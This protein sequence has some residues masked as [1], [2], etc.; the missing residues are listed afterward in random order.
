VL[1]RPHW[2]VAEV[3]EYLNWAEEDVREAFDQL[4]GWALLQQSV[5]NPGRWR[6]TSPEVSLRLLMQRQQAELQE[7]LE[8]QDAITKIVEEYAGKTPEESGAEGRNII[9]I[10]AVFARIDELAMAAHHSLCAFVPNSLP[11]EAALTASL[12][13]DQLMLERGM[14]IRT[15]FAE[16]LCRD[17]ITRQYLHALADLGGEVRLAPAVPTRLLVYDGEAALLPL[18]PADSRLGAVE[19]RGPGVVAALLALFEQSWSSATPPGIERARDHLGLDPRER[20]LLSLLARGLTDEAV[21]KRLGISLRSV[22][23]IVQSLME[24]FEARSRFELGMRAATR[25]GNSEL[26]PSKQPSPHP[27]ADSAP[28]PDATPP[29]PGL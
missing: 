2:G 26:T 20:E 3:A 24:R 17:K 16:A 4:A 18:D 1:A 22:R 10:D 25:F 27:A 5:D 15:I 12:R 14:T 28:P 9:G 11:S 23:R 8:S 7:M 29:E 6:P 19:L 13:N 21:A